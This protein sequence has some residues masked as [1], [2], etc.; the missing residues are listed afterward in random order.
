MWC[1][2]LQ[3]ISIFQVCAPIFEAVSVTHGE[4]QSQSGVPKH[5][6]IHHL[7]TH[8]MLKV[9]LA[10]LT[11]PFCVQQAPYDQGTCHSFSA[12]TILHLFD[13]FFFWG[14]ERLKNYFQRHPHRCLKLFPGISEE[15]SWL[16]IAFPSDFIDYFVGTQNK[17]KISLWFLLIIKPQRWKTIL[18]IFHR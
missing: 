17:Q 7:P 3:D 1:L 10:R 6:C 2:W 9:W 14:N 8:S 18:S 5:L 13:H 11:T 4:E 12:A 16:G 15:F